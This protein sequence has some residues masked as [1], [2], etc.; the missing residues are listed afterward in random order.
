M[1][2]ILRPFFLVLV[3]FA[4]AVPAAVAQRGG[5][6]PEEIQ[7]R[8]DIEHE[9]ESLAVIERKMMVPMRDGIRMAADVYYPKDSSRTYGTIF[10][11]TPY[12]F[13]FWDIRNGV[14][15]AMTA[16][17]DPVKRGYAYVVMNERGRFFSEGNYDILGP[18]L[19]DGH[20][21]IQW[22]ASH[23]WSNGKVGLI[24]CSSTAEWQLAVASTA[25]P[26]LA[27]IIPQGFGAGVGRV[28]PYFEQGNWYRGGAVQMLFIAWIYSQ[29]NQVRPMFPPNTSQ[30]DLIRA[31]TA[32]DLAQQLPPVDWS[33][34]LAHLPERDIIEAVGG[35]HGIFAD[36]MPVA[37]GGAM[38]TRA[39]NDSA[40][41]RG[42]LW[43]EDMPINVPG[44]WFMSWYD[45]SVGPNLA[46]Y[47]HVRH[48][49]R[50]EVADQQYAV[51]A[52]TLYCG[53]QRATED[54]VVGERHLGDA[55]YD[56]DAL[57]YGWFR[58]LPEGRTVAV[59]RHAAQG[60]LLHDGSQQV[61]DVRHL[62]AARSRAGDFLSV[63]RRIGQ[64]ARLRRRAG[65]AAPGP[66]SPRSVHLRPNEPGAIPW[67]QRLL[68][69]QRGPG[70]RVR[71]AGDGTTAGHPRL[72]QRAPHGRD[73]GERSR[74]GDAPRIQ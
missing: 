50:G 15:R 44:L 16:Q 39:P 40:W 8:W 17:L 32:F 69:R 41:Y 20:D 12:N 54:L 11:R 70:R 68:Y 61:A 38:I 37:T 30:E 64:H 65:D 66:G 1:S 72:F 52:P 27:T 22:I 62:A 13:N 29:Q 57:T 33:Q 56:Y 21:A 9:L 42:G 47:N 14:P 67:R 59:A 7:R 73:G 51:I 5:L 49:A 35:P 45:V 43:H 23:P 10:S 60:A 58:H 53:Y 48:T 18:P 46:A 31:S 55:R 24:G 28:G 4:V 19:T 63:E 3:A 6:T 74:R 25:P 34:A 26:G 2:A 36:S 71:S